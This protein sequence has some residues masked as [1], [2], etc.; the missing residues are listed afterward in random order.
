MNKNLNTNIDE[1]SIDEL[2]NIFEIEENDT[3]EIVEKFNNI[4]EQDFFNHDNK[5]MVEFLNSARDKLLDSVTSQ[6]KYID[7]DLFNYENNEDNQN[8]LIE[9]IENM[10]N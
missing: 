8:N 1:Y 3:H 9:N 6:Y 4:F 2:R 10:E 5:K 7:N